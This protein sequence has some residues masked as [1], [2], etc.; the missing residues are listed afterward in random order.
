V[1][2]LGLWTTRILPRDFDPSK[3]YPVLVQVYG[4]PHVNQVRVAPE[5]HALDQ[6]IADHG[7]IVVSIDGRGTPRRGRDWE[8]AIRNAFASVPLEDQVAGLRELAKLEPAMDMDRVGITGW[9]F[10]GFMAALAV[11]RRPDVFHAAVAGA[12]VV[13][14]M[15]YDNC[16]TER[17]LGVPDSTDTVYAANGLVRWA[18]NLSRPLLLLHGTRDDNVHFGESLKLADALF[19]AGRD[20]ELVPMVGQTHGV[21]D[22]ALTY[23]QHIKTMDFLAKSLEAART[24]SRE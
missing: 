13:D 10:G 2:A 21:A 19:R 24:H 16:Y 23:R 22:I 1:G 12:P 20:F 6:W 15:D 11:L 18:P 14:W 8:R 17:F 4:G 5:G 9:S 3:K 7:Y